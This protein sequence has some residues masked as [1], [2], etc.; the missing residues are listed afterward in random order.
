MIRSCFSLSVCGF[1]DYPNTL[2]YIHFQLQSCI[3]HNYVLHHSNFPQ[4]SFSIA[5]TDCLRTSPR[6]ICDLGF[7]LILMKLSSGLTP[8]TAGKYEVTG[9]EYRLKDFVI[10]VGTASQVTTAKGVIVEVEYEPSQVAVQSAQMMN[11]MM[12]MFF[13][14]YAGNRPDVINK[15]STEP[16]S[17]LDTMYQYLTIFRRMR[18]KA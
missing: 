7:D 8:D 13:P 16:Y 3:Q 12:Q 17:A 11:E 6:A 5:P 4:S 10:R 18:K 9:V 15:T 2:N 14:Q 1:L